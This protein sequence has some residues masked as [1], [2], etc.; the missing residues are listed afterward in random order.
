MFLA[1]ALLCIGCSSRKV[2]T[3]AAVDTAADSAR[4]TVDPSDTGVGADVDVLDADALDTGDA[5]DAGEVTYRCGGGVRSVRPLRDGFEAT[6]DHYVVF[7]EADEARARELATLLESAYAGFAAFFLAEPAASPLYVEVLADAASYDAA[8]LSAGAPPAFGGTYFPE[9]Q[10]VFV[11]LQSTRFYT[12]QLLLHEAAHQFHYLARTGNRAPPSFF[13]IEGV[14]DHLAHH[15]VQD[16]CVW[17]GADL[18]LTPNDFPRLALRALTNADASLSAIATG[19]AF[20]FPAAF[21]AVRFLAR[22]DLEAFASLRDAL[23]G[24]ADG[25]AALAEVLA[26]YGPMGEL[27]IRYARWLAGDAQFDFALNETV[28]WD[29]LSEK[30]VASWSAFHGIARSRS[31]PATLALT[32]V[33]PAESSDRWFGGVVTGTLEAAANSTVEIGRD[34]TVYERPPRQNR[35]PIGEVAA[36]ADGS[37]RFVL[38]LAAAT[39]TINDQVFAY[40]AEYPP[41]AGISIEGVGVTVRE[42][43]AP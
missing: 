17:L 30:S 34:G 29:P 25:D 15:L 27:D 36:L 11:F 1:A 39:V 23:D 18:P 3:D 12:R 33:P 4:D 28:D 38:D 20:T 40:D 19:S 35:Q 8:L 32:I 22:D 7:V 21:A 13:Y 10:T 9:T 16:G 5:G 31:A 2:P 6:T 41:G 24:G 14:A 37:Y 43:R 42:I 26:R